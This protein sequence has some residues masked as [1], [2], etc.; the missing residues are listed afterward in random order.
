MPEKGKTNIIITGEEELVIPVVI[1]NY[2]E[3]LV[4][5]EKENELSDEDIKSII[6]KSYSEILDKML[7]Y[8]GMSELFI[9]YDDTIDLME[10]MD[11]WS[12]F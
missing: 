7:G 8:D 6:E 11:V 9:K 10:F 5:I 12:R 4:E 1:E 2:D 3:V